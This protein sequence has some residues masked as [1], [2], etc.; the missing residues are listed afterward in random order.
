MRTL[1]TVLA[2]LA[3][4]GA[5]Q[6]AVIVNVQP[7]ASPGEGLSA[8]K[9]VLVSDTNKIAAVECG[10]AFTTGFTGALYQNYPYGAVTTPLLSSFTGFA[11][12]D[13]A[14]DSH[15]L[16]AFDTLVGT[17]VEDRVANGLG[18]FPNSFGVGTFLKATG[19][20]TAA[21]QVYSLDL[22]QIVIP[23]G[24]SVNYNMQVSVQGEAAQVLSGTIPEPATLALLTLGGVAALI[25]R[26]RA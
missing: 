4:V 11:G 1:V 5:A 10:G 9:V 2:L 25:R 3:I 7:L 15:F 16:P 19:G 23:A 13:I 20:F 17:P 14:I 24:E 21:N 12:T 18:V 22:A 26:R 6:A 8:F